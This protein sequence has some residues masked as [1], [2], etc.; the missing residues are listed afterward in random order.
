MFDFVSIRYYIIPLGM[1]EPESH[2]TQSDLEADDDLGL[3]ILSS[4]LC[5]L[6]TAESL[7][8]TIIPRY[9]I[10]FYKLKH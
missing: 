5:F 10:T 9:I 4:S 2:V 8:I 7:G 3:L 6:P 1:V